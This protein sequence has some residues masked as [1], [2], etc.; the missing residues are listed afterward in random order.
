MSSQPGE[1]VGRFAA[2][3]LTPVVPRAFVTKPF[4]PV[5][6][7]L[8]PRVLEC[9]G[10]TWAIGV[11]RLDGRADERP[12]Y[13][14]RHGR[15]CFALLTFRDRLNPEDKTI[16]FSINELAHRVANTN[17]GRYSRDLLNLLFDLRDTWV[18]RTNPDGSWS[19]FTVL[20]SVRIHGQPVRRKDAL[21]ALAKH[22]QE[23]LWLDFVHLNPDFFGLLHTYEQLARFRFDVL[24]LMASDVAQ[25]LYAFLPARA[26]GATAADPFRVALSDVMREIGATVPAH[27]S[28]RKQRFTQH[29]PSIFKQLDGAPLLRGRLRVAFADSP[30]K[31]DFDLCAW[32]ESPSSTATSS[33]AAA[34][35]D[36]RL[37]KAWLA[38]GRTRA[39]YSE[40]IRT[41]PRLT[42][43]Q[44]QTVACAGLDVSAS[45]KFVDAIGALIGHAALD[46]I[47]QEF[48]TDLLAKKLRGDPGR[49]LV[50]RLMAAA[51]GRM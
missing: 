7:Q 21:K 27:R 46:L 43:D 34:G 14:M 49:T 12:P 38:S 17:G 5:R 4:F 44:R 15:V 11:P 20:E 50:R 41:S 39:E 36:Q 30:D 13:D 18:R 35:K 51:T 25:C 10:C 29:A 24:K 31:A 28:A 26:A 9:E 47:L 2:S 16:H 23:E 40:R 45:E 8:T 22:K 48:K 42:D 6:R 3:D 19:E 33:P 37:L 32:V 1:R